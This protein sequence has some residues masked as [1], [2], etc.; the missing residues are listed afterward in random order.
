MFS[1]GLLSLTV[2]FWRLNPSPCPFD[3]FGN[4]ISQDMIFSILFQ[5]SNA[6]CNLTC[7]AED[8]PFSPMRTGS[9][10]NIYVIPVPDKLPFGMATLLAAACCIPALLSLIFMWNK[11]VELNW[12]PLSGSEEDD[13]RPIEGTNGATNEKMRGINNMVHFFLSVIE[14]P[15]FGGA[16]LCILIFGERNFWSPQLTYQ[17]EPMASIGEC[18]PSEPDRSISL[19]LLVFLLGQWAPI[20]GT[21]LA[22]LGS[23][24]LL[25][26]KGL[27][28]MKKEESSLE[29]PVSTMHHCNCSHNHHVDDSDRS[30]RASLDRQQSPRSRD[31]PIT[32]EIFAS[33]SPISPD[34]REIGLGILSPT[35]TARDD[36]D[37]RYDEL[38]HTITTRS[39]MTKRSNTFDA[40][41]RRRVA[42]TLIALGN[43][44]GTA[45]TNLLDDSEF[46]QGKARDF[47]EIP[48]ERLRNKDLQQYRETYNQPR[49]MDGS[50]TPL[51]REGR[52]RAPSF[53]S[54]A[55][56]Q[57][58]DDNQT[59]RSPRSPSPLPPVRRP[60]VSTYP[61]RRTSSEVDKPESSLSA[62]HP[63]RRDTLDVPSPLHLGHTR[64]SPSSSSI[65]SNVNV[66][67]GE[68]SPTIVISSNQDVPT[69][70]S[71]QG[72]DPS[73][74]IQYP[75]RPS[76]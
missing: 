29:D 70:Q 27:E 33:P 30:G 45:A 61:A 73:A 48:G 36:T 23:L 22:G 50:A 19:T 40:G 76:G 47:P 7:S 68:I 43:R 35:A 51:P 10:N 44:F 1:K 55:S 65:P 26:A 63:P 58:D 46:K 12:K 54:E 16:V 28:D 3:D 21:T 34:M 66:P 41:S 20:A 49:D 8:G 38:A 14:A 25:L 52:S 71:P 32:G 5:F 2:E 67:R 60:R 6:H 24:Y 17:T 72:P 56:A 59:P 42:K 53:I 64:S 69:Q 39:T 13:E 15:V 62:R 57:N 31:D 18:Q 9:A 4:P 37:T 74:P 11:I 75:H